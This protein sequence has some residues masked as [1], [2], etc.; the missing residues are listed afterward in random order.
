MIKFAPI[1]MFYVNDFP[2]FDI[3]SIIFPNFGHGP[4]PQIAG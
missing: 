4:F 3:K 1:I 2:N